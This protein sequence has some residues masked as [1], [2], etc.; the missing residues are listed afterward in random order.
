MNS[1]R[2]T[3]LYIASSLDGFIARED[4]SL[5]WLYATEGEGD[6]G[7]GT[8]YETIDTVIMGNKTYQH[9]KVLADEFPYKDKKC[10]VF[11]RQNEGKNDGNV[12]YINEDIASFIQVLKKQ[13]GSKIWIV[14]GS[15]LLDVFMKE[16]LVD[17]FIV[18]IIPIILGKGI[19]L[20]KADNPEVRLK[21][22]EIQ[23]FGQ[24]AQLHYEKF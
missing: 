5:D 14:G 24:V 6:N 17:E 21:L 19:P 23:Q 10:Y 13:G 8:F 18:A 4:G 20:Y 22:T 11:S 7:Y 16:K 9:T 3:V 12:Q 15:E 2:K 1:N